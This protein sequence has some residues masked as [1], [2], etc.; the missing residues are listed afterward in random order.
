MRQEWEAREAGGAEDERLSQLRAAPLRTCGC[1]RVRTAHRAAP[2]RDRE[3]GR[4]AQPISRSSPLVIHPSGHRVRCSTWLQEVIQAPVS[5]DQGGLQ[6]GAQQGGP[7]LGTTGHRYKPSMP[8]GWGT[9]HTLTCP[10]TCSPVPVFSPLPIG[11]SVFTVDLF[12]CILCCFVHCK[13]LPPALAYYGLSTHS[14]D[15]SY[16]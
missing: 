14:M 9:C 4:W 3:T 5:M 12:F 15:Q 8:V 16:Y 11:P 7:E 2:P 6:P 1:S 10:W 13:Y